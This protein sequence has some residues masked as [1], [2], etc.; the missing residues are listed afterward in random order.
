MKNIEFG[1]KCVHM[2]RYELILRLD[3]ALWLT[4]I[5]KPLLTTQRAIK[6]KFEFSCGMVVTEKVSMI[7]NVIF[8][9]VFPVKHFHCM[10][11]PAMAS[12]AEQSSGA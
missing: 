4:I 3:E 10:F 1:S 11:T 8:Y 5:F 2:G 9:I 6:I 7:C 12:R